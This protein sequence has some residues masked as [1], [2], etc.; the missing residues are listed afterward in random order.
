MFHVHVH[1]PCGERKIFSDGGHITEAINDLTAN[2]CE[3]ENQLRK[4]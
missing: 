1:V 3:D 2:I 4:L